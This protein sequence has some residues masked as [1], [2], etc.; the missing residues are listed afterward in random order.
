MAKKRTIRNIPQ[1]RTPVRELDPE[2]RI[3]NFE[4]VNR[5]YTE[6]EAIL[7]SERCLLCADPKCIAGCPVNIN[8]PDF[9]QKIGQKDY[10][11]AYEIIAETNLLPAVCGRV[12]P[13]ETQCE[14]VCV[15]GDDLI[16]PR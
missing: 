7:E 12:C 11:A 8:I 9:I 10:R 2:R 13:Q 16:L 3:A 14:E 6:G 4:E 1:E 15:V 5:G